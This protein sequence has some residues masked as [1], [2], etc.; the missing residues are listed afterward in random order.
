M[1]A[2]Y[3]FAE[4]GETLRHL[5]FLANGESATTRTRTLILTSH[6]CPWPWP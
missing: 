2:K 4:E 5:V 1:T 6:P 3:S